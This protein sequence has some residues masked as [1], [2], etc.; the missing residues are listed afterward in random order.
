MS[1]LADT[2]ILLRRMQVMLREFG[3]TVVWLVS[4]ERN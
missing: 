4:F 2:N 3:P 1:I